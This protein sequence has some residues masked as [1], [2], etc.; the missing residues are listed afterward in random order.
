MAA[1][2][3]ALL[4]ERVDRFIMALLERCSGGVHRLVRCLEELQ[5]RGRKHS[6][7]WELAI[8]VAALY[9]IR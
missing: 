3:A 8:W 5:R 9:W 1:A 4:N 2:A 7:L 6:N